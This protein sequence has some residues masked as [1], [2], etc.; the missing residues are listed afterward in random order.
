MLLSEF[1][2]IQLWFKWIKKAILKVQIKKE[3][4]ENAKFKKET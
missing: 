3:I 4:I 1:T 2:F